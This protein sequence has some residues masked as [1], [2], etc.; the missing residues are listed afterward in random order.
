MFI[1]PEAV[2]EI[3][4]LG[5]QAMPQEA[6]GVLIL[7]FPRHF[8]RPLTNTSPTPEKAYEVNNQELV[9]TLVDLIEAENIVFARE[10]V[11]IWH[12]HPSGH[13]GP[14]RG[15]IAAKEPTL[16]YLVVALPNGEATQF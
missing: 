15:D 9:E 11:I 4:K 1:P 13:V 5:N 16:N 7:K 2:D 14:S 3:M 8:V 10:D 6:C 12:T